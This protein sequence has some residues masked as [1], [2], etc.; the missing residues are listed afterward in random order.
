MGLTNIM[1][2]RDVNGLCLTF[3]L[4]RNEQRVDGC[5]E[6]VAVGERQEVHVQPRRGNCLHGENGHREKKGIYACLTGDGGRNEKRDQYLLRHRM[7]YCTGLILSF[8]THTHTRTP[9]HLAHT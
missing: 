6:R 1:A 8:E 4:G 2:A 5:C 7:S 9:S 3:G